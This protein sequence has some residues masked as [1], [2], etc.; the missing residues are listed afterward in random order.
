ME[1]QNTDTRNRKKTTRRRNAQET[2]EKAVWRNPTMSNKEGRETLTEKPR[3]KNE[4]RETHRRLPEKPRA[5]LEMRN[6]ASK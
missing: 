6:A 4:S 1:F 3:A 2:T 5:P